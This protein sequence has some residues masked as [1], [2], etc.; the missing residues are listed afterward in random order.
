MIEIECVK[1]DGSVSVRRFPGMNEDANR[2]HRICV[3]R[4]GQSS[5]LIRWL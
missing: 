4:H 1:G 2:W 5:V 3:L